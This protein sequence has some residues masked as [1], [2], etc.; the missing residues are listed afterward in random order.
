MYRLMHLAKELF[1]PLGADEVVR[2]FGEP[3]QVVA[4]RG[5]ASLTA[6]RREHVRLRR[7]L[8][9]RIKPKESDRKV[10]QLSSSIM[11]DLSDFFRICWI[12]F[13]LSA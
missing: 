1:R 8:P 3:P 11:V 5:L 7:N 2:Q 9:V 10:V 13:H 4:R 12:L 6:A